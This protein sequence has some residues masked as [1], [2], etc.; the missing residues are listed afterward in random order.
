MKK[1]IS[2]L[3]MNLMF[4]CYIFSD[5]NGNVDVERVQSFINQR[6]YNVT[7]ANKPIK[8]TQ[9]HVDFL[10]KHG[11]LPDIGPFIKMLMLPAQKN[12]E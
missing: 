9:R 10:S 2:P 3:E 5:E 7:L 4:F 11:I 6:K 12:T 8:I 1:E